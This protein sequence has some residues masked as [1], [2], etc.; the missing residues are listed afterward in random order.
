MNNQEKKKETKQV[1]NKK[2]TEQ[3]SNKNGKASKTS[4]SKKEPDNK[5]KVGSA[6]G[7]PEIEVNE[8]EELKKQAELNKQIQELEE[9]LKFE[10]TQLKA[11]ISKKEEEKSKKE[12]VIKQMKKTNEQLEKEIDTLKIQV[13]QHLDYIE[14]RDKN[15][16][17][18]K[19]KKKRET[20]LERQLKIKIKEFKA[21]KNLY[22]EN[23]KENKENKENEEKKKEGLEDKI[24][25]EDYNKIIRL[26]EDIAIAKARIEELIKERKYFIEIQKDHENCK[27]EMI[28][29]EKQA[30]DL[31]FKLIKNIQQ[32]RI[33]NIA[34]SKKN[35]KHYNKRKYY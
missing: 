28:E 24:E 21:L 30:N 6:Q 10:K 19:D 29:L 14:P 34:D 32:I 18:E 2:T 13:N 35:R 23:D 27:K 7:K 9:K 3:S 22:K 33:K 20:P 12:T 26:G 5:N 8:E 4:P 11:I 15:D 25:Q 17:S 16:K 31:D 1:Q